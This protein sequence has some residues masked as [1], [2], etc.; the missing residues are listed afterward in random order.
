MRSIHWYLAAVLSGAIL[1][2]SCTT[3]PP[4]APVAAPVAPPVASTGEAAYPRDLQGAELYRIDPAASSVHILVYRGGTLA[5]MGHNHVISSK[6]LAGY[7]WQHASL[8]RSGF[9][10]VVPVDQLIVDDDTARA[11][12]GADFPLNVDDNA[13]RGTRDNMLSAALLDSAQYAF[14][15]IKSIGM[16][17]AMDAPLVTIV[18]QIRNSTQA[19]SVPVTLAG[20]DKTLRAHGEFELRQSDFGI[21]PFSVAM[22]AL[23]VLDVVK[24]RFDL[25][26][27][28]IQP[29]D[30]VD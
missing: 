14:I 10:I 5:N 28:R 2:A 7:V 3:A 6:S 22:G 26:A 23:R 8:D 18:V 21:T 11:M 20:N 16:S 29:Q 24:V 15:T 12:E 30:A 13:K 4:A 27:S 17:G 19:L 1:V 9:D 25:L